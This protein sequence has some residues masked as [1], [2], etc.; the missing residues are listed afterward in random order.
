MSVGPTEGAGFDMK[1]RRGVDERRAR[2]VIGRRAVDAHY[3]G[4]PVFIP[5]VRGFGLTA[6]GCDNIASR[7]ADVFSVVIIRFWGHCAAKGGLT[8]ALDLMRALMV[9]VP[10]RRMPALTGLS[11]AFGGWGLVL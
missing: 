5:R 4:A 3:P 2:P 1:D 8:M 6:T 11:G 7:V 9:A 10:A